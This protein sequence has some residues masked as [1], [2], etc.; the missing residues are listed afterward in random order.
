VIFAFGQYELDEGRFELRRGSERVCVQPKVLKLL[1]H[2]VGSRDRSVSAGELLEALWPGETVSA[3]S[4]KRAV[5]GAR[6]ALGDGGDSQSVIRT[7]RGHGYRFVPPVEVVS[8]PAGGQVD[9][10]PITP[11][12]AGDSGRPTPVEELFVGRDGVL[13]A[14]RTALDELAAGRGGCVLLV[15]DPGIGKTRTLREL[16]RHAAA[17]DAHVWF[18]RCMEADGA[19]A[20]WPIVQI[21]REAIADLGAEGLQALMGDGA[22]DIA[23]AIPELAKW[24]AGLSVAPPIGSVAA[25]FRFFDS[26]ARFVRRA[27]ALRPTVLVLDDLQRADQPTLRLLAFVLKQLDRTRV[28]VAASVRPFAH[29]EGGVPELLRELAR[30]SATRTLELAGFD[31]AELERYLELRTGSRPPAEVAAGLYE[32]TAGNPLF[33]EQLVHGLRA[34][35]PGEVRWDCLAQAAA[36]RGLRGAIERH[37]E[38][39]SAPC[40]A[41]L[42]SAA[43][44]GRDFS[45][46][47]LAPVAQQPMTA[48]LAQLGEASANG[49]VQ[50]PTDGV[51]AHRFTHALI[52]DALYDQLAPAERARLHGRAAD[53]LEAHGAATSSALLPELAEHLARAAPLH[54]RGRALQYAVRAGEAASGRLAYEEA[55]LHY[56]RALV[57]IELGAPDPRRRLGLL[58]ARGEALARATLAQAAQPVLLEAAGLARELGAND[59]LVAVAT[60]LA[61]QPETGSVDAIQV[62]LLQE[63][64]ATLSDNDRRRPALTALLAKSLSYSGERAHC[65]QLSLSALAQAREIDD[66]GLRAEALLACHE[67]LAEPDYLEQRLSIGTELERLGHS[68]G[69]A[70]MLLRASSVRVWSSVERGDMAGADAAIETLEALAQ[71]VREP[72][73]RWQAIVFRAM[74]ALLQGHVQSAE[75]L[76]RAALELGSSVSAPAAYHVYCAQQHGILRY[77]GR[78]AEAE[79]LVRDISARHP[80]LNGWRAVLAGIEAELGRRPNAQAVL[81]EL[82]RDGVR[83]L[84]SEPFVLSALAPAAE[85]CAVVGDPE[86]ARVLYDAILPYENQHGNVSF[87]IASYG[88]MARHLGQLAHLMGERERSEQH[89]ALALA[90]AERMQSPPILALCC[91][92]YARSLLDDGRAGTRAREL[93]DRGLALALGSQLHGIAIL[94][95]RIGDRAGLG[96]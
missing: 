84:R 91:A 49:L 44:L 4:V 36:T 64:L 94:C 8:E 67:A 35:G 89:F 88:P 83:T 24:L 34:A 81:A 92:A 6:Q 57:L 32:Q 54:D 1:L 74:R 71:R 26:M 95:R 22:E 13:S 10:A 19:P 62:G 80:S 25:R 78:I 75:Q 7:V 66:P 85:L 72:F 16:A 11:P 47:L 27:G 96:E 48:I 15:G 65:A 42:R 77:Q 31:R 9:S 70:G 12:R 3:A 79:S 90:S 63:A 52:R 28:L 46:G 69:D 18:G 61:R 23:E 2:L 33:L 14:L 87:G 45:L 50:A 60:L 55:A 41:L 73:F 68:H 39:T 21:L 82:M 37:L 59:T 51:G 56:E 76:A 93:L 40:R 5:R 30:E 53:A 86:R 58:V 17:A 20:F 43:V 29:R 38:A